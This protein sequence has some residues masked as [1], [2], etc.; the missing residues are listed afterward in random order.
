MFIGSLSH[1]CGIRF[2]LAAFLFAM[3]GSLLW[4]HGAPGTTTVSFSSNPATLVA[5]NDVTISTL[6][7]STGHPEKVDDGKVA[8]QL[9][10]DGTGNPV[11][12]ASVVTWVALNAPGQN[13]SSGVTN[14]A[15]DLFAVCAGCTTCCTFTQGFWGG[16]ESTSP[17]P[18]VAGLTPILFT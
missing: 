1:N 8:I 14:L 13:P 10:T 12:A 5:G 18:I 11:P 6:T 4:A 7:T 16:P 3:G 2:A 15:V 17:N 9:A